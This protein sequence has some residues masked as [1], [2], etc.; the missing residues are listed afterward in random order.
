MVL[1]CANNFVGISCSVVAPPPDIVKTITEEEHDK[2]KGSK[3]G[4]ISSQSSLSK[5]FLNADTMSLVRVYFG[6]ED[7]FLSL[8]YYH[9]NIR[10]QYQCVNVLH[11]ESKDFG[12]F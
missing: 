11:S 12:N 3:K 10:R 8:L 5:R 7:C 2:I 6:N 9:R 4:S 1:L